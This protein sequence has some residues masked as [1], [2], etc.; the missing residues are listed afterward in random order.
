MPILTVLVV[1]DELALR[2]ILG[3]IVE[4]AG[5]SVVQAA[6]VSEASAKLAIGDI[7]VALC[8]INLPDGS[9]IDLVRE[10]RSAGVETEFIMVTGF[11]SMETAVEALRAGATDYV[12]KPVHDEEIL[13]RLRNIAALRGLRD[14]NATLRKMAIDK[15][16][17]LFHFASPSMRE[18]ERLV[19]KVAPTDSTVLLTGES[20]TGKGVVARAIHDQSARSQM[21]F[22]QVNCSAIPEHL[23]ESEFFGHV[24][25]AFT[26]ADRTRKGLFAQANAGDLFLDEIAE[27][28]LPLQAKLLHV[29]EDKMVRPLGA[30][31]SRRVNTRIIAATNRDLASQV[32]DGKFREDLY[33]RI[34]M[35]HIAMPPLRER[36]ADL[37]GLIKFLLRGR[38]GAGQGSQA[39]EIDQMAEQILLA[40]DWPGNVRELENVI[41]RARI[42]ADDKLV[43]LEDLPQYL[44]LKA[45]GASEGA[46]SS[47]ADGYL[48]NQLRRFESDIIARAVKDAGGDRK[49]AAD[50][51]GIGLSSLYRKLEEADR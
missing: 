37:P 9:G 10:S 17:E 39:I 27:L 12:I 26:G 50:R 42:L 49:L 7:D 21:P 22:V 43:S 32:A 30:E 31:E 35:F 48:R 24:K 1:D 16:P 15:T 33:F 6:S 2:Q 25:G 44:I 38:N 28:P 5:Y 19:S 34:S 46:S 47:E 51:L 23:L 20:G 29:I 14:E 40:Y 45:R 11:A 8:D 41:N 3:G 4:S 36:Q 18:V 13:H